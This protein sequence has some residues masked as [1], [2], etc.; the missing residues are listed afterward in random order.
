[1]PIRD[2]QTQ[3]MTSENGICQFC[4]TIAT[5]PGL[6]SMRDTKQQFIQFP[7]PAIRE[8]KRICK[9]CNPIAEFP[10]LIPTRD[11]NKPIRI[12]FVANLRLNMVQHPATMVTA[13][14]LSCN[15]HCHTTHSTINR[16]I[17][18]SSEHL[19]FSFPTST[20][21]FSNFVPFQQLRSLP[22]ASFP[23]TSASTHLP[24]T[25]SRPIAK[26]TAILST[27]FTATT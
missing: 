8:T 14:Q 1:M 22:A 20:R 26:L 3:K 10:G 6:V 12:P 2:K 18:S 25:Y 21:T 24:Y 13:T 23:I 4:N 15:N 9:F 16:S 5:F 11:T 17:S 27:P 7:R 19:I